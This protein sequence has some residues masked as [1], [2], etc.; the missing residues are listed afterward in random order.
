M[1][2]EKIIDISKF[3]QGIYTTTLKEQE[4]KIKWMAG[5]DWLSNCILA[6]YQTKG[7]RKS[8]NFG[9]YIYCDTKLIKKYGWLYLLFFMFIIFYFLY[10]IFQISFY[11]FKFIIK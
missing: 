5:C 6:Q 10:N 8:K 4:Q 9:N 2:N 1:E 7:N 11:P 3:S